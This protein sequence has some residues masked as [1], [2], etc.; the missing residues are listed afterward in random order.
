M[1]A[2]R[3]ALAPRPTVVLDGARL[4]DGDPGRRPTPASLALMRRVKARFDPTGTFRPGTYVG[5]I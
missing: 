4:V 5:G 2:A 3:E 1:T